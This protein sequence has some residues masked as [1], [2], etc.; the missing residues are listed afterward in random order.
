[1]RTCPR[2]LIAEFVEEFDDN[3]RSNLEAVVG[4]ALD[5]GQWEQAGLSVKQSG[6]G[7]TRAGDI[8]DAACLASRDAAFDECVVLDGSHVWDDGATR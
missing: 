5:D 2:D 1:M 6:L 8:A 4:L 7:L 3:L